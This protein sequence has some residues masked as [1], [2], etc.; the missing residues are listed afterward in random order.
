[1]RRQHSLSIIT[2]AVIFVASNLGWYMLYGSRTTDLESA[3][4]RIVSLE[5]QLAATPK[6]TPSA[7]PALSATPSAKGTISGVVGYPAGTAPAQSI[8]AIRTT[9]TSAKYCLD[10]P[11]GGSLSYSLNVPPGTYYVYATLKAP[12][13]DFS[14]D[15]RAYYNKFVA[16]QAGNTCASGLH[17]QYVAVTVAAGSTATGINPT[18]WYA[19]GLGQ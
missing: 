16:C 10:H 6:P 12:Q 14:T 11:A 2:F 15:Y 19:L 3:H 13:G 9:D 4:A 8:C 1:M 18:D 17:T 7:T 5:H